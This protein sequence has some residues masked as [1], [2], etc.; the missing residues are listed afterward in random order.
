MQISKYE[1][2]KRER[3]LHKEHQNHLFAKISKRV[4]PA[5]TNQSVHQP[6]LSLINWPE[7]TRA[8]PNTILRSALFGS[9]KKGSRRFVE[10]LKVETVGGVEIT[11]TG[12]QLD[13]GDLSVF[14]AI[15]HMSRQKA[16]GTP[17]RFS[18]YKMLQTL[19]KTD[20]GGNREVLHR[21][22]LRLKA[23]ALELKHG[24]VTY[25]GSL[26]G[27]VYRDEI[28]NEYLISLNPKLSSL[29][30]KNQFTQVDW[31]VRHALDT[32]PLAQWL[33]S[34][35]STHAK[36]YPIKVETLHRLC[37]SEA[38]L[39]RFRQTLCEALESV[40]V[41]GKI[42]GWSFKFSIDENLVSIQKSVSK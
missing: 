13:Q 2:D 21:R 39:R 6:V 18:A 30:G 41:A 26:I 29:F 35:Y 23:T 38:G 33:H 15:L 10:R 25:I 22:I 16:M 42:H 1:Q 34:F 40:S 36:P 7:E 5:N 17:C 20:T 8:A 14:L 12:Q 28:T 24:Q 37:G 27:D 4:S 11:Y 9:L 31:L 32:K 19:G 3:D